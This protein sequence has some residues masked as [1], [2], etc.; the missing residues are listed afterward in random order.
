MS[1]VQLGSARNI[2]F[3]ELYSSNNGYVVPEHE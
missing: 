3:K 1:D 2:G